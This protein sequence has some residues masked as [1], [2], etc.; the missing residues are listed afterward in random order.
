MIWI[1]LAFDVSHE[2]H[3]TSAKKAMPV[4][5]ESLSSQLLNADNIPA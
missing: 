2:P 3:N 5:G 1:S 4:K